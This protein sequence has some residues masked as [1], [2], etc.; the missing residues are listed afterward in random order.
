M[1]NRCLDHY[2]VHYN[3]P[4]NWIGRLNFVRGISV[5][6]PPASGKGNKKWKVV[7]W[8][9]V[10]RQTSSGEGGG[11]AG[12]WG[13]PAAL[14]VSDSEGR[15]LWSRHCLPSGSSWVESSVWWKW[16]GQ[17]YQIFEHVKSKL[18]S[19]F[20]QSCLWARGPGNG[21]WGLIYRA[22]QGAEDFLNLL[23][24]F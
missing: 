21:G 11:L 18:W 19:S 2:A 9:P 5:C 13:S 8:G 4:G 3:A 1:G 23:V 10:W 15:T 12:G 6:L 7:L 20:E 22:G 24:C 14:G 17:L 16:A